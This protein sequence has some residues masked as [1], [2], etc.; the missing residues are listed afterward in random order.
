MAL[1]NYQLSFYRKKEKVN[2]NK[3]FWI[4]K[5]KLKYFFVF[6]IILLYFFKRSAFKK[7][8]FFKT[9]IHLLVPFSLDLNTH[10]YLDCRAIAQ[11]SEL[12]EQQVRKY[13]LL[14][15]VLC[16]MGWDVKNV[17]LRGRPAYA[18]YMHLVQMWG[19]ITS[20]LV[21]LYVGC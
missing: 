4:W 12:V 7:L 2:E 16:E 11:M 18:L 8:L 13:L 5:K 14:K 20:A 21:L 3:T 15:R 6:I 1:A 17:Q 19:Y 9:R 10:P